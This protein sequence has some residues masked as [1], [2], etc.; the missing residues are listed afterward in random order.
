[1]I[2]CRKVFSAEDRAAIESVLRATLE[3]AR[4]NHNNARRE[5]QRAVDEI[6]SGMPAPDGGVRIH[7]AASSE[8]YAGRAY[9]VAL[10]R[11]Y[12]FLL[13]GKIPEDFHP[14]VSDHRSFA[15]NG[16]RD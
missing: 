4:E 15:T 7:A 9:R 11:L 10:K 13:D 8:R 2:R 3:A 5:L 12:D 16:N 6:P 14:G 1:M